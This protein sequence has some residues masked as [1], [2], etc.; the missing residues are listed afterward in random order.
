MHTEST[1]PCSRS[2]FI[3]SLE[4]LPA[5]KMKFHTLNPVKI[6]PTIQWHEYAAIIHTDYS[7]YIT[8]SRALKALTEP[9]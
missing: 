7:S 6:L 5:Q 2:M 1:R 3:R 8:I 4:N 9:T